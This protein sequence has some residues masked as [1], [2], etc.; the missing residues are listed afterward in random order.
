MML[1][2]LQRFHPPQNKPNDDGYEYPP[3]DENRRQFLEYVIKMYDGQENDPRFAERG[4]IVA[5]LP[6]LDHFIIKKYVYSPEHV[7][8]GLAWPTYIAARSRGKSFLDMGTGTGIAAIYVAQHGE[9]TRVVATDISPLAVDNC[10]A[11]AEQYALEEPFFS[12]REGNVFSGVG[13]DEKFDILFWNFPWNAPDQD[14]EEILKQH[15]MPITPEKV[16]QLRAGLDK[17]YEAL[18]RFIREGRD[19]LNPQ[20]EI[21][22]GASEMVRHDIIRGEAAKYGYAIEVADEKEMV[23][24]TI[25]NMK[26]KVILY[27]LTPQ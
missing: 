19:H 24:D 11:N 16:M 17:Q 26:L 7:N 12:V 18:R 1:D 14:I 25:G 9:P 13:K 27:R 8:I 10:K 5:D 4:Q 23:V 20:G 2:G 6:G 21:L 15:D 3:I 22:L